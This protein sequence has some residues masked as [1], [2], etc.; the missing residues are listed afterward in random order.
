MSDGST[1]APLPAAMLASVPNLRDLGGLPAADGR[2]VAMGRLFRSSH[3]HALTPADEAAFAALGIRSV[4]DFR[5]VKERDAA[6]SRGLHPGIVE[7]HLPIEPRGLGALREMRQAGNVDEDAVVELMH[8][9]Y[10]RFV[11]QHSPVFAALLQ[12]LQAPDATPLLF[13]CT[14]GKDRT[15]M[16]AM[17]ILLALG[18]PREAIVEDFMLSNGRWQPREATRDWTV[19]SRVRAEYLTTAFDTMIAQSGSIDA[20]LRDALGLDAA[21]RARLAANLL[22]DA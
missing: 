13:H 15:G 12:R 16:G 18:V 11:Q 4:V 8:N 3:L 22:I 9:A 7:L 20:H 1:P 17:L 10:R 21:A 14:A 6:L 19:L 2:R 5:G